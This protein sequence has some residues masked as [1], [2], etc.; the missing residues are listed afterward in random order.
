MLFLMIVSNMEV[1]IFQT[2]MNR[3]K[4]LCQK[5]YTK[6]EQFWGPVIVKDQHTS[7]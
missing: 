6:Q 5:V 2:Y 1:Q 7:L 4:T 3:L